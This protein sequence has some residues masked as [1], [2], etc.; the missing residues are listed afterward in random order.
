[1]LEKYKVEV[2]KRGAYKGKGEPSDGPGSK[3]ISTS[4]MGVHCWARIF[5]WFRDHDLHRRQ[6][7]Q[8]S[9]TEKEEMRQQQRMK[10]V[11]HMTKKSNQEAEWTRKTVGGSVSCW[12]LIVKKSL[13]QPRM[14]RDCATMVQL[15]SEM[16]EKDEGNRIEV[17]HQIKSWSVVWSKLL[18]EQFFC[19]ISL[20]QRRGEE[21]RRF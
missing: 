9:Q 8:E 18:M 1:M 16:K 12:P 7:M 5:S 11:T 3:E 10:V 21:E 13:A 6:D 19:T 15:L 2:S 4:K 20:S 17:E 14:G